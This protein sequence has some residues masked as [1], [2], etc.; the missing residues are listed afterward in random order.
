MLCDFAVPPG[1]PPPATQARGS[2][3]LRYEAAAWTPAALADLVRALGTGAPALAGL[4]SERLFAA[5]AETVARFRDPGS[6]E[7]QA[8]AAGLPALCR[9]SPAGLDVALDAVLGG[10]DRGPAAQLLAE[11]ERRA[12]GAPAGGG[13][14]LVVLA[15]NLPALVV[16]PL[17]TLLAL[18]RPVLLESSSAE[19]LFAPAFVAALAAREPLLAGAV[20][21]VTWKGGD[22][23]LEAPVL[24]AVE[25]VIAY[26]EQ[27]SLEDL[28][29][30]AP[31]K[32]VGYG[33]K[34]SLA[35]IARDAVEEKTAAGLARDVALFDQ[36]GCLSVQEVYTDGD[37][38]EL[39]R[40][41]AG[42]L[43]ALARRWPPGPAT[44]ADV[45]AVQQLRLAAQM[46]GLE[47]QEV[48]KHQV[49]EEREERTGGARGGGLGVRG[50][51]K[52]QVGKEREGSSPGESGG[53]A[54][55]SLA[56][57]TVVV[58]PDP[59][60]RSLPGLRTVRIHPLV[61]LEKLPR[62]LGGWGG[63]LQGAAL[64]GEA[65]WSLQPALAALGVSRCAAPGALQRPDALWHNGGVHP[66]EVL[67]PAQGSSHS[68][69]A[70]LRSS[71]R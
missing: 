64:A 27:E 2:S 15:G 51:E 46:G 25:R 23:A 45:A 9:L 31:G 42:E 40:L 8:L 37:A 59:T 60:F 41:L 50:V 3:G 18:R 67:A 7:R 61:D 56:A 57:G 32:V 39:A 4:P 35:V 48:E 53:A 54:E 68:P 10:V 19:P 14:V 5:W 49:R 55:G 12:A 21:A 52:L 1:V 36:R 6:P 13:P 47:V 11:A 62:L 16:Q 66:L 71:E 43:A 44:L 26:G 22:A 38:G 28:E 17:L 63:R 58:E 65:A 33:P 34:T 24:A 70:T 30:R 29:R 69:S 20:A